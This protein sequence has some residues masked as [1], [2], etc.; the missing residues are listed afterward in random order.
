HAVLDPYGA[1]RRSRRFGEVWI[2]ANLSRDWRPYT[3]GHWVYTDD[4]GWYWVADDQEADWGWIT[5]HYGR[6]DLD[7]DEGWVLI[8]K[9]VWGPAWVV[10]RYG[11]DYCG[12]A[13]EPPDQFVDEV[14][15]TPT[16]WN[17]V[18]A[19]DLIAPAIPP[20]LLPFQRR[21]E[22]FHRTAVVNRPVQVRRSDQLFAINP[23]I[24]PA[25]IAAIRG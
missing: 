2:P 12:W 15:D 10:W 22:F 21:E 18:S 1:W 23:G 17:F 3:V 7:P 4:Y 8:P 20:V 24:A 5:Y 9:N 11:D 16:Y 25:H 19:S 6:W 14:D 13:P